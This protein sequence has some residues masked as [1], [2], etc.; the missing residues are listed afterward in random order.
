MRKYLLIVAVTLPM[1]ALAQDQGGEAD[2]GWLEGIIE[3]NLSSPGRQV[4]VVGFEGALSSRATLA[5]LTIA[6][7]D[8]VWL[9]LRDVALDWSRSA[10]LRGRVEVSEL[11]AGEIIVARAPLPAEGLEAAPAPE[12][13]PFSLPDLPV[14]IN[15]GRIAAE[16]LELGAPL[17]GES[18]IAS[19][20]GMLIL[21]NG[22]G[23]VTLN[24]QRIDGGPALDLRLNASF[25]NESR[26]LVMDLALHDDANGLVTRKLGL[27]GAPSVDLT[28]DGT[29][30][31]D[32]YTAQIT[33]ATDA[34][35]RIAGEVSIQAPA[36]GPL[37]F[38][39]DLS[40]NAAPLFLPDYAEFFGDSIAL[41][42]RGTQ[43]TDGV[44]DIPALSLVAQQLNLNG[45]VTVGADGLPSLVNLTGRIAAPDGEPVLLPLSTEQETRVRSA[46]LDVQFD[47]SQSQD[48]RGT[49]DIAGL[50]RADFDADTL[51]LNASGR[52]V[53]GAQQQVTADLDLAATGLVAADP[54]LNAAL[55]RDINGAAQIEWTQ[56]E[57]GLQIPSLTLDGADYGLQANAVIQGVSTGMTI[58][59]GAEA[60]L[61]DL[62]RFATIAGRP[63]SGAAEATVS[64]RYTVLEGGFDV[65]A[66]VTGTD[67]AAGIPQVDGLLAGQSTINLSALRDTAGTRI[68]AFEVNARDLSATAQGLIASTG[69]DITANVDARNLSVL[70]PQYGG[71]ATAQVAFTGTAT[72]GDIRLTADGTDIRTGIAEADGLLRGAST[73]RVEAALENGAAVI[74]EAAVNANALALTAEGRLAQAGSDVTA[75]L[76]LSDLSVMG[77]QYRGA[78][79]TTLA[80]T[81]TP[82][83]GRVTVDGTARNISVAQDQADRLLR[84][85]STISAAAVISDGRVVVERA[86]IR[87]PQV[88][89][90]A[91]GTPIE[92]GQQ[93]DLT[94]RL[95]NLGILVPQFPGAVSVSGTV[96]Q[97]PQGYELN[98]NAQGPGGINARANGSVAADFGSA[99]LGL[100][101]SAQAAL[102]DVFLS[103]RSVSGPVTFDLRVNGPLA[104]ESVAGTIRTQGVRLADPSTNIALNDINATVNLNGS[105]ARIDA[106]AAP[107]EGGRITANGTVGLAE[108]YNADLTVALSRAVF[109]DPSLFRT[110]A[111]GSVR[112]T[113]PLTGNG[114]IAG[115][116]VLEETE[117]QVPS[118]GLGSSGTLPGLRHVGDAADVRATRTRA[119]LEKDDSGSSGGSGGG[120]LALDL[121]VEAPNQ[122]FVRG[123]GL[124]AELGGQLRL[125]GTTSNVVPVGAFE[126][127]RGRLDILG[128]RLDLTEATLSLEGDFVPILQVTASSENN[129]V[130]SFVNVIGPAND[131]EVTFT[132]NPELPQEEVLAQLLFGR[133]ISSISPLQAAQLANA[134]ATLAGGGSQGIIGNLRRNFGLDDLDVTTNDTGDAA[135]RAGKYISDKAYTQVEVG[136]EG[137]SEISLNLDISKSL[138]LRGS[139]GTGEGATGIGLFW[140]RDY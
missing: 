20:D 120:G 118:G 113:G 114:R 101:G 96:A 42:V 61:G 99:N 124:D 140:E 28:V 47:A 21:N 46:D 4:N 84:G 16:R 83:N 74:R 68:R 122:I 38:S 87:N 8:G 108:P 123:R 106:S 131:P 24:A 54:G 115:R 40:G 9:T 82:E 33:L 55:G 59:G 1:T 81:G 94:A 128:R 138:T 76:G 139:T 78:V 79:D 127:V 72:A 137:Q 27:P 50:D 14:S 112:L 135:V 65:V 32:D 109:S 18:V 95:A 6:D 93:L 31:I 104:L 105:T 107:E 103:P 39:A 91:T 62:S 19:M 57:D 34:Q 89:L 125:T 36:A 51:A 12:A 92:G 29:A 117:I 22:E 133:D 85:D 3:D 71:S 15:I 48:W 35:P 60:R 49:F 66:D 7:A 52:I 110:R 13:S 86:D 67:L 45:A 136:A 121:T 58:N 30:P 10:L 90:N 17:L 111:G 75:R 129:G 37:G 102:A 2:R 80:F 11:V 69:S 100:N 77:G 88:T 73:I 25:A 97:R 53:P 70:G 5:E 44:I 116:I 63:L 98:L 132:S 43:G 134:V 56:G 119:G 64:G 41:Q 26:Q 130:T 23:G 126:L